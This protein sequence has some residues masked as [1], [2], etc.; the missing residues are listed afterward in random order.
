MHPSFILVICAIKAPP[1]E[2]VKK[3]ETQPCATIE[4]VHQLTKIEFNILAQV[5]DLNLVALQSLAS[6]LEQLMVASRTTQE[7][8][9]Q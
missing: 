9:S 3:I 6:P 5:V 7:T 2:G 8:F 4:L 1:D